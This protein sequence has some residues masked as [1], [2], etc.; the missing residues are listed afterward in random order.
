MIMRAIS[1]LV[2]RFLRSLRRAS[3]GHLGDAHDLHPV[4]R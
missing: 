4:V 1:A 2:A 3:S